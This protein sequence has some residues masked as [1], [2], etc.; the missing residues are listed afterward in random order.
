MTVAELIEELKKYP[1]DFLVC[2]ESSHG[3]PVPP[4]VCCPSID[5]PGH[6]RD[7]TSDI[8]MIVD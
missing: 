7:E 8:V 5:E 2:V 1:L 4:C 6:D 3:N